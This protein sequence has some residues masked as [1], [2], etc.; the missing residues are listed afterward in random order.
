[1]KKMLR[2]LPVMLLAAAMC[3][4]VVSIGTARAADTDCMSRFT[5]VM[6]GQWFY[7]AI[8]F[9]VE[10]GYFNGVSETSFAPDAPMTRAMFVTVLG[11]FAGVEDSEKNTEDSVFLDVQPG[12]YYFG[13]VGWAVENKIVTGYSE[14]TFGQ[15]DH[16]TRE[17]IAVFLYR[18]AKYAGLDTSI[19]NTASPNNTFNVDEKISPWAIKGVTWAMHKGLMKGL[20]NNMDHQAVATRAEVAQILMNFAK[21]ANK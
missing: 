10:N 15:G 3:L 11:R 21:F 9:V 8:E 4:S 14:T 1:M 12:S 6:P 7:S 16:V 19:Q 18:Y 20:A 17:Q 2:R 13:Y 5:D